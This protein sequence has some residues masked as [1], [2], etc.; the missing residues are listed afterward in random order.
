MT[1]RSGGASPERTGGG[2]VVTSTAEDS[3]K[4]QLREASS[5]WLVRCGG[6][7]AGRSPCGALR[8]VSLILEFALDPS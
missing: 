8:F 5:F 3:A 7:A 1:G 6:G 4:K 2:V